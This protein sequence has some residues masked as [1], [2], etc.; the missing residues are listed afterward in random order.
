MHAPIRRLIAITCL[1]AVPMSASA[2]TG[3]MADLRDR[4]YNN[5]INNVINNLIDVIHGMPVEQFTYRPVPELRSFG[6]VVGHIVDVQVRLCGAVLPTPPAATNWRS[7]LS[8]IGANRRRGSIG[9]HET[10]KPAGRLA[11]FLCSTPHGVSPFDSD[12]T[13]R[14]F[15]HADQVGKMVGAA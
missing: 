8:R 3:I 9:P 6:E 15:T 10:T 1:A 13:P 5:V 11:G 14:A 2:Q 4:E 12:G 7:G